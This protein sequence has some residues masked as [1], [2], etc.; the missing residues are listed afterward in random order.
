MC[1]SPFVK[2]IEKKWYDLPCGKCPV[3]KTRR[4]SQWTFRMMKE[5]EVSESAY[6]IT[7][8][9]DTLHVPLTKKKL[10]TLRKSDFQ[11]FMKRLRKKHKSKLRYY[12]CGEYGENYWRPHYHVILFNLDDVNKV[13][14]AWKEDGKPIGSVHIG[15]VNEKTIRY[16][17]KY[18]DKDK[19]IPLWNGDDRIKEYSAMSNG[20]GRNYVDKV[21]VRQYHKSDLERCYVTLNGVK[22][23]MPRYYKNLIYNEREMELLRKIA[24]DKERQKWI[25]IEKE[26]GPENVAR[27]LINRK[28]GR[29]ALFNSKFK[30]KRI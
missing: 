18:I 17:C 23:P 29:K 9:Y 21:G 30:S 28:E 2:K 15:T 7:L 24:E 8:T 4:V 22:I 10:M 13:A 26:Y 1:D 27:E 16:T 25:D 19:R 6:F 20:L 11:K 3:C 5:L 14:D 12:M